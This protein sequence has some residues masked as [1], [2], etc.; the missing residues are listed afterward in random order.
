MRAALMDTTESNVRADLTEM[1]PKNLDFPGGVNYVNQLVTP[2]VLF[3]ACEGREIKEVKDAKEGKEGKDA[4]MT[5]KKNENRPPLTTAPLEKFKRTALATSSQNKKQ[6][7]TTSAFFSGRKNGTLSPRGLKGVEKGSDKAA[8][9][10]HVVQVVKEVRVGSAASNRYG[11]G[12][13]EEKENKEE[14]EEEEEGEFNENPLE[15]EGEEVKEGDFLHLTN[16]RNAEDFLNNSIEEEI[17]IDNYPTN[18]HNY[19]PDTYTQPN[20]HYFP[21][22]TQVETGPKPTFFDSGL[23]QATQYRPYTPPFSGL[24]SMKNLANK[25][26]AEEE[27]VELVYDPVMQCYYDPETME[28]YQ[29]NE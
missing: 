26:E 21:Q 16:Y 15:E 6:G 25:A 9:V 8:E 4:K 14:E 13:E 3:A 17:E 12:I 24:S 19:K 22:E 27:E 11:Q 28:F 2:E 29:V 1:V 20:H 10:P 7:N 18:L 5:P 23:N